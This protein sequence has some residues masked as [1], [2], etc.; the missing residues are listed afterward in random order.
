LNFLTIFFEILG[1]VLILIFII[2]YIGLK[3]SIN[4]KKEDNVFNGIIEIKCLCIKIY[5]KTFNSKN[6]KH[7][8][9]NKISNFNVDNFMDK[10]LN[11]K[12][13]IP[14]I[15]KNR[16]QIFAFCVICIKS[17]KLEKFNTHIVLGLH[18][19]VDTS[20]ILGYL[21]AFSAVFN[22]FN[23]FNLSGEPNYIKETVD[24][25]SEII[26]KL[27]LIK[28]LIGF[29]KLISNRSILNL[30]INLKRIFNG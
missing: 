19:P 11:F 16:S 28:P 21:W 8:D 1:I 30:I 9:K 2:L 5:S 18:S 24:F 15:R 13:L 10:L 26:F 12:K 3:I 6:S 22:S 23:H 4:L 27:S 14:N 17:I 20:I 25:N 7:S 29:L